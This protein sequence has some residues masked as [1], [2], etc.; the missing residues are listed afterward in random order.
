MKDLQR[1]LEV[2]FDEM[3]KGTHFVGVSDLV[4]EGNVYTFGLDLL[5]IQPSKVITEVREFLKYICK[6]DVKGVSIEG[7]ASQRNLQLRIVLG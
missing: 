4:V 1:D 2:V 3:I 5:G 6:Y 7:S